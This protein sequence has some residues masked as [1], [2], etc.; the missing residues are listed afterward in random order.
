[1]YFI[2]AAARFTP[3]TFDLS[4][5]SDDDAIVGRRLAKDD[6][7]MTTGDPDRDIE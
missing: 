3:T 4:L 7:R 2:L 5:P 1:M 6:N